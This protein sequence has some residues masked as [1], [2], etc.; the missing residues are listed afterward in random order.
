MI[1]VTKSHIHW[2]YFLALESDLELVARFIEFIEENFKTYSI[3]LAHL[4][5]ASSSEIDVIMKELCSF[6]APGEKAEN[7]DDYRNIIKT[8][9]PEFIEEPVYIS[10]YGLSLNPWENWK[11]EKNPFW[12]RSYN[13]VKHERNIYFNEANLNNVVNALG[14][15]LITNFYYYCAKSTKKEGKKA[16]PMT[17][18]RSLQPESKL[19]RLKNK[20]YLS[21]ISTMSRI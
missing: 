3:E 11:V 6:L 1:E 5:L 8:K 9:K 2:N 19:F 13:N 7:I 12:W 20:Y 18:T 14:A 15:L 10:R 17:I 4:L 16:N 21:G